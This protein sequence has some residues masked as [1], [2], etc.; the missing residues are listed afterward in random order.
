M[1]ILFSTIVYSC[2]KGRKKPT[3]SF[4]KTSHS[5]PKKVQTYI[6]PPAYAML[7]CSYL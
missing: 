5:P 7:K 6:V 4:L 1:T 3:K 2:D